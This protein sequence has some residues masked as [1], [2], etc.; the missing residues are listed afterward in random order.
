MALLS[1]YLA[2]E[3][4][5]LRLLYP[6]YT[7]LAGHTIA[8]I[9]HELNFSRNEYLRGAWVAQS[10]VSAFGSGQDSRILGPSLESGYLLGGESASA[11]ASNCCLCSGSSSCFLSLK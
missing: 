6:Q 10:S 1:Q 11:S 3:E 5:E 7:I 2:K 9:Q 8:I 4:V